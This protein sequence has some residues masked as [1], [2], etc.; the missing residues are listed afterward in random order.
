MVR[1]QGARGAGRARGERR[2]NPNPNPN[3]NQVLGER[4]GS[5][6]R[7]ERVAVLP[8]RQVLTI[9]ALTVAVLPIM[10]TPTPRL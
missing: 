6:A 7:L 4:A 9:S 1:G 8:S 3:P 5:V 10:A 2:T